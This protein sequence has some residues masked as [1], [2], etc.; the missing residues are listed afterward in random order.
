[1]HIRTREERIKHRP[2]HA[3]GA[4]FEVRPV[5]VEGYLMLHSVK[6]DRVHF[7]RDIAASLCGACWL[8]GMDRFIHSL[9]VW[10][11]HGEEAWSI[12]AEQGWKCSSSAGFCGVEN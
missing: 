4:R 6:R 2:S 5:C 3:R 11:G 10:M 8:L 1:V 12:Y 7:A 9:R